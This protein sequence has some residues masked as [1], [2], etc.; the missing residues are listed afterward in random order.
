VVWMTKD[1]TR[2]LDVDGVGVGSVVKS[3]VQYISILRLVEKC[4]RHVRIMI[5]NVARKNLV[6]NRKTTAVEGIIVIVK[7]VFNNIYICICC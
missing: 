1:F 4:Q 2:K 3:S 5:P 6:T 7:N